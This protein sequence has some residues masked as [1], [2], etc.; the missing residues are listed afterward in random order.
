MTKKGYRRSILCL[1]LLCVWIP[2]AVCG[3]DPKRMM[4]IPQFGTMEIPE[5]LTVVNGSDVVKSMAGSLLYLGDI[6]GNKMPKDKVPDKNKMRKVIDEMDRKAREYGI[7]IYQ[8]ALKDRG[9]YH[10]AMMFAVKLPREAYADLMKVQR[11]IE[12]M[13]RA[14]QL[15]L[16]MGLE[17]ITSSASFVV[18]GCNAA[19]F[20]LEIMEVYPVEC[21]MENRMKYTS[22]GGSVA[23]RLFKIISPYA[24]KLYLVQSE[25]GMHLIGFASDGTQRGVW[26][27]VVEKMMYSVQ[28]ESAS[29]RNKA[30]A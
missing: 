3:A 28:L 7:G 1:C 25:N 24:F 21:K 11:E 29:T 5:K 9:S 27:K 12:C 22:V 17:R 20:G 10:T 16:A 14:D 23:V 4:E 19:D 30:V 2:S 13:D 15:E 26:N 18:S 8:L 6:M